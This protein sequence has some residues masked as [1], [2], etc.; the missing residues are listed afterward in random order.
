[1]AHPGPA[2]RHD[3]HRIFSEHLI[4]AIRKLHESPVLRYRIV[5]AREGAVARRQNSGV[6]GA[7]ADPVGLLVLVFSGF[8]LR[9]PAA[10]GGWSGSG[11]VAC[12]STRRRAGSG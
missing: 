9:G 5:P 1:M 12:R 2:A 6:L 11:P 4:V 7:W 10:A 8:M 3:E